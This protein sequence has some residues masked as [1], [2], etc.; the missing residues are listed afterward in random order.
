MS[1]VMIGCQVF[2]KIISKFFF[3]VVEQPL[4]MKLLYLCHSLGLKY[5]GFDIC[6]FK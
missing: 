5:A 4:A 2:L 3:E 1:A 6:G